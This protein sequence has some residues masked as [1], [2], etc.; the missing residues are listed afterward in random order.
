MATCKHEFDIY[1]CVEC[2]REYEN[3]LNEWIKAIKKEVNFP[4]EEIVM[5]KTPCGDMKL[6]DH[7]RKKLI[8]LSCDSVKRINDYHR[9]HEIL[10]GSIRN[11]QAVIT[12]CENKLKSHE[13][14]FSNG[15]ADYEEWLRLGNSEVMDF[16]F[17]GGDN[18]DDKIEA[19]QDEP[20]DDDDQTFWCD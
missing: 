14:W 9:K 5:V 13:L 10:C 12:N 1:S 8:E 7:L 6:V 18:E 20:D 4:H 11:L 15:M 3:V 17:D 19:N 16:Q 2:K